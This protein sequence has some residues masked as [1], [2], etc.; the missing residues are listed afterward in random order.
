MDRRAKEL[1]LT[2]NRY[3]VQALERSLISD[4]AWRPA[5]VEELRAAGRDPELQRT[6][7]ELRTAIKANRVSK[8]PWEQC[9]PENPA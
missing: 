9:N 3:I 2:R 5:F 6:V 1:R 4:T 7:A 8:G